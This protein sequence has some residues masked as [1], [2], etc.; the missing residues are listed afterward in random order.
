MAR[1][2]SPRFSRPSS[3]QDDPLSQP[4]LDRELPPRPK[5]PPAWPYCALAELLRSLSE[6]QDRR[7]AHRQG[8]FVDDWRAPSQQRPAAVLPRSTRPGDDQSGP[9]ALLGAEA[10]SPCLSTLFVSLLKL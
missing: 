8:Q 4:R 2:P 10:L 6:C 3:R 1:G 9:G 7:S 5:N